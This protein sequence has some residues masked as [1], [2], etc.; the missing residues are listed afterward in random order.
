VVSEASLGMR[1]QD[2]RIFD[3]KAKDTKKIFQMVIMVNKNG[4]GYRNAFLNYQRGFAIR[5]QYKQ[6]LINI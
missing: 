6:A 2:L 5:I 4:N 1:I 3:F